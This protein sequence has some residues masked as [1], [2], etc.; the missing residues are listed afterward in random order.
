MTTNEQL[1][2]SEKFKSVVNYY[3][4]NKLRY[5]H[6]KTVQNFIFHLDN[7]SD[8]F[9]KDKIAKS[10][11]E[12]IDLIDQSAIVGNATEARELFQ[13]YL[14]PI[15]NVYEKQLNFHLT[16]KP[17]TVLFFAIPLFLFSYMLKAS[18]VYY[19]GLL[20]LIIPLIA[21]HFYYESKR[22]VYSIMY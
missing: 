20:A 18:I 11:I 2:I 14:E 16:I 15:V 10:L 3:P 5:I 1:V 17:T 7:F 21:R 6:Y 9:Q 8:N 22:L 4:R 13:T 19:F 12:Y